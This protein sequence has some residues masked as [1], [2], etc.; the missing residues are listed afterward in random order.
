MF[1][2]AQDQLV[3]ALSERREQFII[4][5]VHSAQ[6]RVIAARSA[7]LVATATLTANFP[8]SSTPVLEKYLNADPSTRRARSSPSAVRLHNKNRLISLFL[9]F[10]RGARTCELFRSSRRGTN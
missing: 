4:W 9:H 6:D 10:N 5:N 3:D 7:N 8:S 1:A 2:M